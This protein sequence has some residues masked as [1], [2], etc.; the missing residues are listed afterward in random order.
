MREKPE[1]PSNPKEK[2]KKKFSLP[3][4]KEE[5]P[6]FDGTARAM[7]ERCSIPGQGEMS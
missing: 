4:L 2:M 3:F 5:M 7:E 1:A 6:V